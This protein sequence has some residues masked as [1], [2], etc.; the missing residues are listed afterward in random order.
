MM[1]RIYIQLDVKNQSITYV[2]MF[3]YKETHLIF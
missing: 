2:Y 1:C 3:K